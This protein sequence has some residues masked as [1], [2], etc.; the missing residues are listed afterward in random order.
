MTFFTFLFSFVLSPSFSSLFLPPLFSSRPFRLSEL[1]PLL[2]RFCWPWNQRLMWTQRPRAEPTCCI[3][4]W[5]AAIIRPF[6][7]LHKH[8][9]NILSSRYQSA[10]FQTSDGEMLH[11]AAA[12]TSAAPGWAELRD[13][14]K[15]RE[16]IQMGIK[17]APRFHL[18]FHQENSSASELLQNKY[19]EWTS[20]TSNNVH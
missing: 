3:Q 1:L 10:H 6:P 2:L 5:A 11:A 19:E 20:A 15:H 9:V 16:M 8:S 7:A 18:S 13:S 17:V 4:M 12:S 14:D